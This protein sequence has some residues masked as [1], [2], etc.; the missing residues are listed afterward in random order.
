MIKTAVIARQ[1]F[2]RLALAVSVVLVTVLKMDRSEGKVIMKITVA[3]GQFDRRTNKTPTY[4][5]VK[6]IK[7]IRRNTF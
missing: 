1:M 6:K 2:I 7:K 5:L 4:R 3:C